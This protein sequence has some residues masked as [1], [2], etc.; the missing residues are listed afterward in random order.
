MIKQHEQP[1][2]IAPCIE[3]IE[4]E[5]NASKFAIFSA[6]RSTVLE[7]ETKFFQLFDTSNALAS[8]NVTA[9]ANSGSK[10]FLLPSCCFHCAATCKTGA[11]VDCRCHQLRTKL[12]ENNDSDNDSYTE[13]T[14]EKDVIQ[15]VPQVKYS[16]SKF[17][18]NSYF[19]HV[20]DRWCRLT[21][22]VRTY[23]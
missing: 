2:Q 17:Y 7:S 9:T 10:S 16:I 18:H 1:S 4:L 22:F 14:T 11:V 21:R 12:H 8:G 23:C 3:Q 13:D 19:I 6:V 15:Q 5:P 20:S